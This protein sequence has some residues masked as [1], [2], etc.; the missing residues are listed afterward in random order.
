MASKAQEPL[1]FAQAFRQARAE[2]GA[3]GKFTWN[4]KSYSTNTK[5]D[6]PKKT[7]VSPDPVKEKSIISKVDDP[8]VPAAFDAPEMTKRLENFKK[9]KSGK[10][11]DTNKSIKESAFD[12]SKFF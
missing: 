7:K 3:G 12:L 8:N 6:L 5:D 10:I 1:T 9:G 4:G 2:Q 11:A